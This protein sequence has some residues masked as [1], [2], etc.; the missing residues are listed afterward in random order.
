[1]DAENG[2]CTSLATPTLKVLTGGE[3][4]ESLAPVA[5]ETSGAVWTLADSDTKCQATFAAV[6]L[7][8]ATASPDEDTV[9]LEFTV[10]DAAANS[11]TLNYTLGIDVQ[12]PTLAMASDMPQ[13]GAF[14][15][16][17]DDDPDTAG[18][19]VGVELAAAVGLADGA[20]LPCSTAP[21]QR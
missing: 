9:A 17:K 21:W 7:D 3:N 5:D 2:V 20:T 8:D 11:V 13:D 19:Q 18:Q 1:M 15:A 6:V 14:N 12:A 16:E 10:A 4:V